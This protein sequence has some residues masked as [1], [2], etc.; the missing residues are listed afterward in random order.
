MP[1][2]GESNLFPEIKDG[3]YRRGHQ[4]KEKCEE[5]QEAGAGEERA[6][7]RKREEIDVSMMGSSSALT[8]A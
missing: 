6:E 8:H 3:G 1:E 2:K 4:R 5:T 7:G